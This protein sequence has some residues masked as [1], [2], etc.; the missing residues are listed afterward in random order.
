MPAMKT[1]RAGKRSQSDAP[2]V[3]KVVAKVAPKAKE[4]EAAVVTAVSVAEVGGGASADDLAVMVEGALVAQQARL[5]PA[6]GRWWKPLASHRS[7]A[8]I[9]K[10]KA[11]K[12]GAWARRKE[13]EKA[14]LDV[15]MLEKELRLQYAQ[16]KQVRACVCVRVRVCVCIRMY[17]YT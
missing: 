13:K 11:P 16:T 5:T 14:A 6:S 17:V 4:P 10:K 15:R 8:V 12:G 2:A 1:R 9:V 3:H 7:S